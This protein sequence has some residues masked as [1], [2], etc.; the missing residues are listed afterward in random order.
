MRHPLL[1][2]VLQPLPDIKDNFP[3]LSLRKATPLLD[4]IVKVALPTKFCNNIAVSFREQGL[5]KR[6]DIGMPQQLQNSNFLKDQLLQMPA[7]ELIQR[8]HLDGDR[9][10]CIILK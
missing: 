8:Y 5:Y 3:D 1:P 6:E 7:L 10:L 4:A 9:L 2:H